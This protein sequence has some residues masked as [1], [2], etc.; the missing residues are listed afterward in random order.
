M[1]QM[2]H[3]LKVRKEMIIERVVGVC[4]CPLTMWQYDGISGPA[5]CRSYGLIVIV[6]N[7]YKD[8]M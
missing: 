8:L 5:H 3:R 6:I 4:F 1:Q 7:K 2:L